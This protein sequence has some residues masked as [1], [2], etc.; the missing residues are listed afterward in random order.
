VAAAA[1]SRFR[2]GKAP[3]GARRKHIRLHE[4]R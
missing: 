2:I 3:L 1:S 4:Q